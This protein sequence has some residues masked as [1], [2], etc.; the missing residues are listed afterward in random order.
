[1]NDRDYRRGYHHAANRIAD[2]IAGE[3]PPETRAKLD[4]WI[5]GPLKTWRDNGPD[6]TPPPAMPA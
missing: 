5:D 6:G 1:M 2:D 3:L 4:A